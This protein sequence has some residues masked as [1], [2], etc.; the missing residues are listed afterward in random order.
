M[1]MRALRVLAAIAVV[2][3]GCRS[4]AP[5]K[6]VV[7]PSPAPM[8]EFWAEP[9]SIAS[10]SL[11]HGEGGAAL[12]PA[13]D[14]RYTFV[15]KK[16]HG[17]SPGYTVKDEKG[18]TWSAKMGIEAQV[19]VVVSRL[20]WAIGFRQPPVYFLVSWTLVDGPEPGRKSPARFR[21]HLHGWKDRGS[22]L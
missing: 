6:V 19:E 13:P 12:A 16:E 2:A 7:L 10:R 15:K 22:W 3:G 20:L 1:S 21:P 8:T 11:L 9:S 17:F 5:D 18:V 14:A 4:T